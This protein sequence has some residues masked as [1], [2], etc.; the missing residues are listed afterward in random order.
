MHPRAGG[1][2]RVRGSRTLCALLA[3]ACIAGPALAANK[4]HSADCK[5]MTRQIARYERDA[6]WA[7][8]RDNELWED[9][10]KER[11]EKLSDRRA[12]M[13]P[14][15]RRRNPLVAFGEMVAEAAK[16]AAPYV[17]PGL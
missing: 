2:E 17:I 12:E 14:Q 16:I 9:A 5:R 6:R 1:E 11:V 3:I 4:P 8:Q 7:D 10:S 13:C 15:Y